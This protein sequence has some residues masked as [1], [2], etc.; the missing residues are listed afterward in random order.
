MNSNVTKGLLLALVGL[1]V[2]AAIIAVCG[3]LIVM[4]LMSSEPGVLST[5]TLGVAIFGGLASIIAFIGLRAWW[6]QRKGRE[7]LGGLARLVVAAVPWLLLLGAGF[8]VWFGYEMVSDQEASRLQIRKLDCQ[9]A[10]AAGVLGPDD[11]QACMRAMAT[12]AP[13]MEGHPCEQPFR[14]IDQPRECDDHLRER[15]GSVEEAGR[16]VPDLGTLTDY[17]EREDIALWLCAAAEVNQP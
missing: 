17:G 12:C 6:L 13:N 5:D 14:S 11:E 8:G 7:A 3:V 15:L 1:P 9:S 4:D 16:S 2:S 10:I